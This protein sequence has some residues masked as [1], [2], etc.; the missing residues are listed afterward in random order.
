[1]GR[2]IVLA[3]GSS[4]QAQAT[5]RGKLFEQ[6]MTSVLR[7]YGYQ[8]DRIANVNYA[9]MEIDI[10]GKAIATGIPIYAECKCYATDVDSPKFQAFFG[11]Y[12]SRWLLDKRCQGLFIA[13]P[14]IN[15]YAKGFYRENCEQNKDITVRLME[16][17]EVLNAMYG[18]S[19]VSRPEVFREAIPTSVGTAGDTLIF[20]TDQGCFVG[21]CIIPIGV[22]VPNSISLFDAKG[23]PITSSDTIDYVTNLWPELSDFALLPVDTDLPVREPTTILEAEQIVEVRGSSSCF[24]YQFPASPEF[25]VG[26][27]AILK[28]LDLFVNEV[29]EKST[30]SRGLV[31]EAYSGWGK[32]STVLASVAQLRNAG[33][34]AVAIDSRTASSSQFILQAID[35]AL[36]SSHGTNS[37]LV[38]ED[39]GSVITGFDGVVEAL[40]KVG[41]RLE[42]RGKVLF[43]FLDQF[44]N[45]FSLNDA[46]SRIRNLFVKLV[47]VQTNVIFGFSWKTDLVGLTNEFPYQ[48]R[49]TITSSSKRLG[50]N[51]FS[52]VETNTLLDR[53]SEDLRATLRKD[54][55]FFLSEFSQG[56]PWLLKKL[57]A[58]VKAQRDAGVHQQNIAESLL[59][60]EELFQGDLRG[61]SAEEED[62]LR[63]IARVAPVSV[64]ELGE[65]FKP[66]VVQ[67][68]VDARLL[69]RVGPKYDVYWDIFR[70][71]LNVGKLPI[72]ENYILHIPATTMF[73]H[74]RL[75]ADQQ[76]ELILSAFKQRT[77][78]ADK[79]FYNVMR[80]MRLLGL[81]SLE[82]ENVALQ[83]E[84]PTEERAF[85]DIF[86]EHVRERLRRNRLVSHM[87]E[88]LEVE[89]T[90]TIDKISNLLKERCP[91]ISA[92]QST[93]VSYSRN[94]A[95]WMDTADLA[96]YNKKEATID[97]YPPGTQLRD[98]NLLQGR[99]RGGT[100][101]PT[102][103]YGAVE[104]VALRVVGAL[105]DNKGIDWIGVK[106]STR[107]KA[108]EALEELK[109]ITR[110]PRRI[111]VS[112]SLREFVDNPD[113]RTSMFASRALDMS[114]FAA[115][116]N[117]LHRNQSDGLSLVQL[118]VE[119]RRELKT[120]WKDSTSEVNAK[121]MLNWARHAGLAPGVFRESS[122]IAQTDHVGSGA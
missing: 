22:G 24:E 100:V 58:H 95:E 18:T 90:L 40:V 70:D 96:T 4:N 107:T 121:V 3:S 66:E 85:E 55:R 30:S 111:M 42:E 98:R 118:G 14:G 62:T 64:L 6:L 12:M 32:S 59:N 39:A 10:D 65:E 48:I 75:L 11:K 52:D 56:Y 120:D 61:L 73:K 36:K 105:K 16:E 78:L 82:D 35:Y 79:S 115:F 53:L 106:R 83:T 38:Q 44:E 88:M 112:R 122:R 50:L 89:G 26:R 8:I 80:E 13:L 49:D 99:S 91:Y 110:R 76:G 21:Q 116:V 1:M 81:V 86:R 31:F 34:F 23:N 28:D 74:T 33:H 54:L 7:H 51:T 43:M 102:I 97:Y 94:F 84:L 17:E 67:S 25:F 109:F 41:K 93:W 15:S 72:Q 29:I 117:I 68:L 19:L 63:R 114:S 101:V 46:L 47:D 20:Y 5:A 57:C 2:L 87:L 113:Q 71:Y 60:V 69:V 77:Q 37:P 9:G 45:V 27:E 103:Q 119:L 108:L 92:T 104:D